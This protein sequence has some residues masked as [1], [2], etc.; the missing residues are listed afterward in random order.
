MMTTTL[1]KAA[2]TAVLITVLCLVGATAVLPPSDSGE[3]A[4]QTS[5]NSETEVER[6]HRL[7]VA[8]AS[9]SDKQM[10]ALPSFAPLVKRVMP[11]VV[12]VAI[13]RQVNTLGS[14]W[15]DKLYF[16]GRTPQRFNMRGLGS[17]VDCLA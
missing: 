3:Q 14:N 8:D 15:G 2:T 6:G 13:T 12:N 16:L 4:L 7:G 5:A 10:M 17:G 1:V 11:T 9:E